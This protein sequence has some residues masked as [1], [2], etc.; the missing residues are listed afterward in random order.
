MSRALPDRGRAIVLA[1]NYGEAGMITLARRESEA[2]AELLPPAYSGH[3][4]FGEWGPPPR[5]ATT[6]V[7]IGRWPDAELDATFAE[8]A[9][10]ARLE[11][12]D[13]VD[14]DEDGAPVQ[15]CRGLVRPWDQAWPGLR[16][17]G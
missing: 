9:A 12:P 3:N 4:G 7:V 8:C 17:L 5:E 14:N 16:R 13:G 10:V 15:V 11:T 6:A 2:D 1:A